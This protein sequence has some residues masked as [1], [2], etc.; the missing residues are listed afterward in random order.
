MNDKPIMGIWDGVIIWHTDERGNSHWGSPA[1]R[2]SRIAWEEA[3]RMQAGA[4]GRARQEPD[5]SRNSG[6]KHRKR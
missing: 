2:L 5:L 4:E 6:M 1:D 3:R